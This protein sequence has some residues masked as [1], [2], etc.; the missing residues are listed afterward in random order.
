MYTEPYE[1]IPFRDRR[2]GYPV[3][4]FVSG[5]P[6]KA[7]KKVHSWLIMLAR[8]GPALARPYAGQLGD[9]VRELR[10]SFSRL[11]IRILYFIAERLVV[12]TNA[13][14]KKD[15]RVPEEEIAL[16]KSR[17]AEWLARREEAR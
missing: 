3:E 11:E 5:L 6:E 17:R 8:Q 16:C 4:D 10:I 12:V 14:L 7:R 13:F 9:G 1:V 15:R 2:G